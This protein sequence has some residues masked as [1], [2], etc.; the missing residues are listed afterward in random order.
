MKKPKY[1]I[2]LAYFTQRLE[3]GM[4]QLEALQLYGETCLHSTVSDLANKSDYAFIRIDEPHRH[5]HGGNTHFRRYWLK[6]ELVDKAHKHIN[7]YEKAPTATNETGLN[8]HSKKH[9]QRKNNA[10]H[11]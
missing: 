7:T 3:Q 11:P 6:H 4:N 5:Q 9:D 8:N 10:N 2:A 1:I